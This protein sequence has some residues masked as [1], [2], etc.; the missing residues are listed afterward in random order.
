[1][2]QLYFC[3][4]KVVAVSGE[5][6]VSVYDGTTKYALGKWTYARHGVAGR[7]PLFSCLY[8]FATP[9]EAMSARFP[10]SSRMKHLP[11]VCTDDFMT[12]IRAIYCTMYQ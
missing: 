2:K 8:A 6:L 10:Q 3:M 7:P 4:K 12:M 1:M 11:K 9:H 5:D